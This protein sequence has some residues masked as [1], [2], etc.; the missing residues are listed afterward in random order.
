[1]F[2]IFKNQHEY[3]QSINQKYT[4]QQNAEQQSRYDIMMNQVGASCNVAQHINP[5]SPYSNV[6]SVYAQNNLLKHQVIPSTFKTLQNFHKIMPE[7]NGTI[8]FKVMTDTQPGIRGNILS[9]TF[10]QGLKGV[11][12][13]NDSKLAEIIN[14]NLKD[15]NLM[16]EALLD[17][18][19]VE[20]AKM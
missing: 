3:N 6:G 11:E 20:M 13:P 9:L 14:A 19:Y 16:Q 18:G 5:V 15:C 2:N 1:M 10:I 17:A 4:D 7:F 8:L 12:I